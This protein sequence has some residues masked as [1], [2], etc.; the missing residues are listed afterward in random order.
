VATKEKFKYSRPFGI[1][2]YTLIESV[3]GEDLLKNKESFEALIK[4]LTGK[5]NFPADK[6]SKDLEL[7]RS[8]IEKF[9]QAQEVMKDMMA[10][11]R[12]KREDRQKAAE[13]TATEVVETVPAE[14]SENAS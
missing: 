9:A 3:A 7:Y 12:K 11:E 14:G 10:A 5:L 8:N 4:D 6:L 13:A 2:L 1:G